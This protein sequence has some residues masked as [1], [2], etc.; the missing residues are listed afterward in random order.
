MARVLVT[1]A[2]GH[3]G[4]NTI[5]SLL[6][7]GH[8][9][10]PFVRHGADLSGIQNLGLT[11]IM[12]FGEI[13]DYPSLL[14]AARGCDAIIHHAAVYKLWSQ[15]PEEI[16]VSALVGTQNIFRAASEAGVKRMIYTSSMAAVGLS[17]NPEVLLTAENWNEQPHS[18]YY[19]AKTESER[20]ALRLSQEFD[21]PTLRICPTIVLGPYDYRLTPS[22]KSVLGYTNKKI[23]TYKGGVNYVHVFDVGDVHAAAV[24]H[25][26]PGKRYIV[27]GEN[28]DMKKINTIIKGITGVA[29]THLPVPLSI[30][31]RYA[32]MVEYSSQRRGIEPAYDPKTTQDIVER[33][34]YYDCNLTNETFDISPR[35]AA[36]TLRDTIRWLLFLDKLKP[37]IARRIASALPPSPEW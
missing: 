33:Y 21:I 16:V 37:S 6:R 1:G 3:L 18:P 15:N 23:P 12:R 17:N 25:G 27:G 13:L 34:A 28:L 36:E 26:E 30:A 32:A 22:T 24:D 20:E 19:I 4:A 14:S 2:N 11:L 7:R 31:T 10:V 9:I 8:D 29:P 35:N 5:R